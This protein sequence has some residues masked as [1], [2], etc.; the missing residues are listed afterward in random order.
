VWTHQKSHFF[1]I[2]GPPNHSEI[3][4]YR[5]LGATVVQ[6][7]NGPAFFRL[8]FKVESCFKKKSCDGRTDRRT[9][10][11]L[12]LSLCVHRRRHLAP[13]FAFPLQCNGLEHAPE[14]VRQ[15]EVPAIRHDVTFRQPH[16]HSV[17]LWCAQRYAV[18]LPPPCVY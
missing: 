2:R 11:L 7:E 10:A 15:V 1:K 9:D 13:T 5:S 4:F 3:C 8:F 18:A 12:T 16:K 6:K 14:T 17:L